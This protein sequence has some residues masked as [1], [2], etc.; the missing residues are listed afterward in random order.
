V[1]HVTSS[2]SEWTSPAH[3][4]DLETAAFRDWRS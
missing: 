4:P 3:A 2:R 1:A